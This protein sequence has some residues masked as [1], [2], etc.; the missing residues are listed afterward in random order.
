MNSKAIFLFAAMTALAACRHEPP[1][2]E[3][4][5]PP[6][7][8]V[9]GIRVA[10]DYSSL[11]QMADRGGYPRLRRL[12]DNSLVAIYETYTGHI[13]LRRSLDEGATW[14][15]PERIFSQSTHNTS[16]ASTIINKANPEIFQLANG[17]IIVGCNYRPAQDGVAPFAIAVR[18]SSDGGITWSEPQ[19][20]FE[21]GPRFS[22]GCWEPSFLQLPDGEIH[23]YFANEG[24]YLQSDEQEISVMSSHDDGATWSEPRTVSF[25][26]GKR[27]GMPV[28]ALVGEWIVVSIEDNGIDRF[29]PFTVR[30]R[31]SDNWK[32]PVLATSPE[33]E[34]ALTER[35]N[36]GVYMGAP[37]LLALPSG[38]TLISYQTN[39]GRD[40]NWEL[41]TMEVAIGDNE[42]RGFG[43]RTRPFDVPLSG[44]AKWNSIALWDPTTVVA[45]A[46][47]N[48]RTN[49]IAPW[50]IKGYII[51]ELT[52][53][54][55]DMTA[56]PVFVGAKG[57]SNLR[58]GL[59]ADNVNYYVGCRVG[60]KS[61][62]AS[63]GVYIYLYNGTLSLRIWCDREG[64][65]SAYE[66]AGGEWRLKTVDGLQATGLHSG[67]G[68]ELEITIPKSGMENATRFGLALSA[69]A[70][71]TAGYVEMV[72]NAVE[73]KP[74]SWLRVN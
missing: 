34:R 2:E 69:Y 32:S 70:T 33:R 61:P 10:W 29:K 8:E 50:L 43:K 30:T 15:D 44:E 7:E 54:G 11:M 62:A 74:N 38:G 71:A 60:D 45:F 64:N 40:G 26:A 72:A 57:E 41:S 9:N 18:R 66:R 51:P 58:A 42:A 28:A 14:S 49:D 1:P 19:T 56:Y 22:D 35:I 16:G 27:D 31:L 59:G 63:D 47:T 36:D 39:E 3:I 53:Q 17:D 4:P 65:V 20:I 55:K 37:Y 25:R 68:Y 73:E 12:K 67:Q 24:P 5:E 13:D 21:A 46:S 23:V 48:F 52:L 6:G